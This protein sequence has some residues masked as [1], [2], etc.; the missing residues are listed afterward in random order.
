MSSCGI[1]EITI[2]LAI[3][4]KGYSGVFRHLLFITG[5]LRELLH[6]LFAAYVRTVLYESEV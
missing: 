3:P 5:E 4:M 6:H 1:R 2:D